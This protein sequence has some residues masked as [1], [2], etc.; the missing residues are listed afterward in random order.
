MCAIITGTAILRS[1]GREVESASQSVLTVTRSSAVAERPLD[2]SCLSVVSFNVPTARFLPRDAMHKR[3]ICRHA[4]SV[5]P[6]V[7]L[8]SCAKTNKDIFEF[9]S[10][11]GSHT[12]LVFPYQTGWRYSDGNL[13]NGGVECKWYEKNEFSTNISLY[14]IRYCVFNVQ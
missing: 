5:C 10:P 7:T 1:G 3:I 4:V 12:I 9:F 13:P 6:S 2:T 14:T 11:Y 8:V